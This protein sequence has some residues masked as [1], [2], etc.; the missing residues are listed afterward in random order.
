M[1]KNSHVHFKSVLVVKTLNLHENI[2]WKL[3][4]YFDLKNKLKLLI[5]DI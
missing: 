4:N 3:T 2:M 1:G 5:N